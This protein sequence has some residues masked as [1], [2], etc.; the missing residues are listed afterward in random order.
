MPNNLPNIQ[1]INNEK[2][3]LNRHLTTTITPIINN[4][5][6]HLKRLKENEE[7]RFSLS[8]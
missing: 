5:Q 3:V 4:T 1:A 7:I 6:N 8:N 2:I